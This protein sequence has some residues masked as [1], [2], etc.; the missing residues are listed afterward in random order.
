MIAVHPLFL[1][2]YGNM[3]L[4]AWA[5]A[6]RDA[7]SG[8]SREVYPPLYTGA[9]LMTHVGED[10]HID[11]DNRCYVVPITQMLSDQPVPVETL[12]QIPNIS[13][14]EHNLNDTK[15]RIISKAMFSYGF[16]YDSYFNKRIFPQRLAEKMEFVCIHSM[17]N[18]KLVKGY[19][20]GEC[21]EAQS[22]PFYEDYLKTGEGYLWGNPDV[23]I[24]KHSCA[25]LCEMDASGQVVKETPLPS[26]FFR[27]VAG[28]PRIDSDDYRVLIQEDGITLLPFRL[29]AHR[30]SHFFRVI[31][32]S[33]D[34]PPHGRRDERW[35]LANANEWVTEATLHGRGKM[36][37][38]TLKT[39]DSGIGIVSVWKLLKRGETERSHPFPK[40]EDWLFHR[41]YLFDDA[42][43]E[44]RKSQALNDVIEM[45]KNA[46][47]G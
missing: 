8:K 16:I 29:F 31:E 28:V 25:V 12:L 40:Q 10:L 39:H 7:V 6:N 41:F 32:L 34:I 35:W 43:M 33:Q 44:W 38:L 17:A 19:S 21:P 2:A 27:S 37:R 14:S 18:D 45:I 26:V 22:T 36:N 42:S 11:I 24:P 3:P 15:S 47:T 4:S 9:L 5:Q 20:F 30:H 1:D 23:D 46:Q 13:P